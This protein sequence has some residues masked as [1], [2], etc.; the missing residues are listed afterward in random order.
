MRLKKVCL[1]GWSLAGIWEL[2]LWE[3][4]SSNIPSADKNSSLGLNCTIWFTLNTC[5]LSGVWSFGTCFD[6][7]CLCDQP[8]ENLQ[9]WVSTEIPSE[10]TF[11]NCH[12]G[13]W[14]NYTPA[15]W[16]Y[17]ERT[18]A[19]LCLVSPDLPHAPFALL[20]L[21]CLPFTE[22]NHSSDLN[23]ILS[24]MQSTESLNLGMA[25]EIPSTT[26]LPVPQPH[27]L[28]A[29]FQTRGVLQTTNQPDW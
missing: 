20:I 22:I 9:H 13:S 16:L 14:R 1:Q 11:H 10:K 2:G 17:R 5:F 26:S 19:S 3:G 21:L 25:L 15:L 8:S 27:K 28:L 12:N 24:P 7:G 23:S 4:E 6:R 18:P 29:S